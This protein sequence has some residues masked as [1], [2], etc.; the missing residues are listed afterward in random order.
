M[1]CGDQ[2]IDAILRAI[3]RGVDPTGLLAFYDAP[4]PEFGGDE[5]EYVG[6]WADEDELT[7]K[8]YSG[9]GHEDNGHAASTA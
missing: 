1:R 6:L 7:N 3:R 4:A 8:W 2:K 9:W 5:P